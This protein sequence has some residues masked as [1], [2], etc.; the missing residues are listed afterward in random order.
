MI[1]EKL[2]KEGKVKKEKKERKEKKRKEKE[3]GKRKKRNNKIVRMG[4]F[5]PHEN[6]LLKT[7]ALKST[8]GLSL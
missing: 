8:R 6:I 3:K 7:E 2:K 4:W 5:H 1:K